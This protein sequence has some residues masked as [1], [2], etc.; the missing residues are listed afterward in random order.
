MSSPSQHSNDLLALGGNEFPLNSHRG[1]AFSADVSELFYLFTLTVS[2]YFGL[3]VAGARL[4]TQRVC[5]SACEIPQILPA[6]PG[7]SSAQQ[8]G[9]RSFLLQMITEKRVLLRASD[10]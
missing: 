9:N 10:L 2:G 8:G 6:L 4:W 1:T 5:S 3:F 7:Q